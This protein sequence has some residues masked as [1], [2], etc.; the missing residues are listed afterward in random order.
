MILEG[1]SP[2]SESEVSDHIVPVH[3]HLLKYNDGT[4]KVE[5]KIT[6]R[7]KQKAK[8]KQTQIGVVKGA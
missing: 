8:W 2:I 6:G 7:L 4:L 5:I 3:V 1:F